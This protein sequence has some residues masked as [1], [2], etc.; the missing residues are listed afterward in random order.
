[1]HLDEAAASDYGRAYIFP[2]GS[3]YVLVNEGRP[4]WDKPEVSGPGSPFADAVPATQLM[5]RQDY[6]L[7]N[8]ADGY[9]V[10]EGRFTHNWRLPGGQAAQLQASEVVFVND[11]A[12]SLQ[13][14]RR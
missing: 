8:G 7:F 2:L 12:I 5:D 6:L 13:R 1:M 11:E 3:N 4:W 9:V 10:S 14:A